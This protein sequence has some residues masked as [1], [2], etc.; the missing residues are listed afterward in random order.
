MHGNATLTDE[1]VIEP[2]RHRPRRRARCRM[3]LTAIEKRLQDSG[4]FDEVQ[5]RK[6]YRTLAMDEV[7]LVLV[8]HESPGRRRP[9]S[10][11]AR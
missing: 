3:A 5:V 9:A 6:R 8:V 4:R 2:R 1:M 11:P 7:A 10:R